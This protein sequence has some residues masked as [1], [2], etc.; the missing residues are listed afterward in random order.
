MQSVCAMYIYWGVGLGLGAGVGHS[1]FM[2][3]A[4]GVY[5]LQVLFSNLWFRR[6]RFGPLEW[7]WRMLTYGKYFPILK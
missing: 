6:F 7:I 4:L 2:P 5:L 3:I 1:V